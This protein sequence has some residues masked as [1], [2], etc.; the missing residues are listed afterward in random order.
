MKFLMIGLAIAYPVLAHLAVV[1][2][3]VAVTV[4]SL[5][6]LA[7]LALLPRRGRPS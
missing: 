6:V 7:S 2:R 3:S 1:S 4:A 5:A